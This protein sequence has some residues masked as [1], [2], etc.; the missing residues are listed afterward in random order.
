MLKLA[1]VPDQHR[2]PERTSAAIR[3]K[4][5]PQHLYF[6]FL[7]YS[8]KD[9]KMADW[10][11]REL[12][13]FRVPRSL[14]GQLTENGIVP[15][16]LA[17]VFRDRHEL[18]AADD[19]GEEIKEALASSRFLIVLCSPDAAKSLWTNAEIDTFKR[20][21]PD[22]NVLA[23][24]IGGDPFA[25]DVPGREE[26]ECF[27]VALRQKYDRR[28]RPT[29]KRAEPLAADFRE[30]GDGQRMGFLKLVA[31]MLGVGL[32][33][34]VQRDTTRRHRNLAYLAAASLA[35]MAVTSGLA[36]T[37]IQARDAARD[38]RREAEGL[39][40]FMLGD[41]KDKL[42]PIGRLDALD[43]VGSRVLAYY[44]KQD[45][46]ELTDP[47]LVQ[48]ARALSL[49]AQVAYLRG[50]YESASRLYREAM[51]GTAEAVERNPDD[52]QR[53]FDHAQNVFWVGELARL[54]GDLS[55]AERA[56]REYG[57]LAGRMTAIDPDNLKWRMEVQY[58]RENLGIVLL[59]Q[60]RF[61]EAAR[62]FES[63]L[64]PMETLASIDRNN[65]EYQREVSN[66]LAWLGDAK[67]ALGR[68]ASAT[69]LRERQVSFIGQ[70]L[71]A[72]AT[73]VSL[74]DDLI[75]AHQS[76]GVLW[77]ARGDLQRGND[78]YRMA[79][80]EAGRLIA[81]EPENSFWKGGA[82][83]VRLDLAK[84]LLT[85]GQA[86]AAAREAVAGCATA[87]AL[88]ARDSTV[89]R[90]RSLQTR[91]LS[92]R[93]RL[94]LA[95][96]D[97]AQS[98]SLAERALSSAQA[99]RG[100]D[101]VADRYN[102]AAAYRLVGDVRRRMG[103]SKGAAAAWTSGLAQLPEKAA[104]RP[105]EMSERAELLRRAGRGSEVAAVSAKLRQIG[106]KNFT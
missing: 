76:L 15:K 13:R 63:A 73:D 38:Q 97:T 72:G 74:R 12:E 64:Q 105:P 11:H 96:G 68:F 88:R 55:S 85:L 36:I 94:A 82:A 25:S 6:A 87:S 67:L 34:L 3:L 102:I 62:Q 66:L 46:S 69:A 33:D 70:L 14:A 100:G 5:R 52:P 54:Q 101:P 86:D 95:S 92:T 71:A 9:Q 59:G 37:A 61:A 26:E 35:G 91:C 79:L 47:A 98:L 84:N 90:W 89:A 21:R 10:L 2:E 78:H 39:V 53:L 18:A 104:E 22:A 81:I 49:T 42:E 106:Y 17:P 20:T 29:A 77:T 24:I 28:G 57:R 44:S 31:G 8:H 27:P 50:N 45:A 1:E 40:A 83:G 43:G 51:A 103:D 30:T 93:A 80:G 75:P 19:L 7:S 56:Y 4:P 58:A 48:R 41:L 23:A 16:R 60:R 65:S 99:E 32:D